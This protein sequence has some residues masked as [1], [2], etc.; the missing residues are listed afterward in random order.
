[1]PGASPR[2]IAMNPE[3]KLGPVLRY[4]IDWDAPVS[5]DLRPA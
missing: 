4:R 1:M 5:R 2:K 3:K